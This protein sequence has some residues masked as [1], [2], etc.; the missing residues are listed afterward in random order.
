MTIEIK[1]DSP[2]EAPA[3]H[4]NSKVFTDRIA[5][6]KKEL[7]SLGGER[8]MSALQKRAMLNAKISE[9]QE[10]ENRRVHGAPIRLPRGL[11]LDL[12]D[13]PS[14]YPD[15]HFRW[16]NVDAPGKAASAIA[17]GY[18]RVPPSEGGKQIGDLALFYTSQ[19]RRAERV[20][21]QNAANQKAIESYKNEIRTLAEKVVEEIYNKTGKDISKGSGTL[22]VEDR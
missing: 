22:L 18:T 6:A 14:Q 4:T 13:L 7:E 9:L 19:D 20:G 21:E 1:K 12:G 8:S 15:R 3:V 5:V 10:L 16:V 11:V 2:V 17:L